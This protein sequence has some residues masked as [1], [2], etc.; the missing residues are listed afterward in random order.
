[1]GSA[2]GW[3]ER[4]SR[5]AATERS[6]FPEE[7]PQRT[8][9]TRGFPSVTVPVLSSTTVSTLWAVSNASAD[10]IKIPLAAPRPVPTII[11]VGVAR[12]RAQGQEITSTEMA[13][14]RENSNP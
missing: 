5:E 12:P 9:V 6:S 4:L 1:M 7:S 13:M 10:L 8:S 3:L 2:K 11:A 14:E